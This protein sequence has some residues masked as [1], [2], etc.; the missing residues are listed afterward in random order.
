MP[1]IAIVDISHESEWDYWVGG[2]DDFYFIKADGSRPTAVLFHSAEAKKDYSIF[3]N[4]DGLVDKVVADEYIFIFR[5][6][7]GTELD[8][9]LIY[10]NGDI[11]ISRSLDIGYNW[12]DILKE[13]GDGVP[14]SSVVRWT[15][16]V[17]GAV[18]CAIS[19]KASVATVGIMTPVAVWTCGNYLLGLSADITA[20]EFDIHNGFTDFA[21]SYGTV[22]TGVSCSSGQVLDC[23]SGASSMAISQWTDHLEELETRTGDVQITMGAMDHGSGDVQVTL[24]WD[25]QADLDLMVIDPFNDVV[26]WG[27]MT[28]ASGGSLDV[29]NIS[30][31]G[32]ENIFWPEGKAPEGDYGVYIHHYHWQN[33]NWR[34]AVAKYTVLV[35]AF[36][37]IRKF[38]GSI[39]QDEMVHITDFNTDGFHK[40]R[41]KGSF[42]PARQDK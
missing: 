34:P 36:G 15:G 39:S 24:T 37:R 17:V 20:N 23:L 10:P 3:F 13:S 41:N 35:S 8:I 6:Y 29:D 33:Q 12:D 28:S 22:S 18:P 38:T 30:G 25:N 14:W 4:D 11:E 7:N 5:N 31:F 1:D 9:G 26:W 2:K 27:N 21:G 19:V 16:R 42:I 40:N 32:P